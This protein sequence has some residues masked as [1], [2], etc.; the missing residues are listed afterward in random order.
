MTTL[1]QLVTLAAICI[2]I[3]EVYVY[4]TKQKYKPFK[5]KS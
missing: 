4:R 1:I 2:V 3:G 5:I